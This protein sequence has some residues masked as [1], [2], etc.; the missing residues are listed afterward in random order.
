MPACIVCAHFEP[1]VL[2]HLCELQWRWLSAEEDRQTVLPH[3]GGKISREVS[4]S[5]FISLCLPVYQPDAP[6]RERREV[7]VLMFDS[8]EMQGQCRADMTV[9]GRQG[10]AVQTG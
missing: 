2:C 3:T 7:L 1:F 6:V 8:P 10:S 5:R 4:V 9:Q